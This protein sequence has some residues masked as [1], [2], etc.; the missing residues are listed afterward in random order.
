MFLATNVFRSKQVLELQMRFSQFERFYPMHVLC[1]ITLAMSEL[2]YIY[3]YY[4]SH[5]SLISSLSNDVDNSIF[6]N[7]HI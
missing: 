6:S 2:Y 3:L 7:L 1:S 4:A 5:E